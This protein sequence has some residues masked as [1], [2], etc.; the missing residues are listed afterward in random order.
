MNKAEILLIYDKE[1]PACHYYCQIVRIRQSVGT[2]KI[3]D[4]REHSSVMQAITA[5]GLDID[6][7]VPQ[8]ICKKNHQF[9]LSYTMPMMFVAA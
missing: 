4:A 2:L 1:C 6:Q 9:H 7:G 3:I 8:T 5:Q